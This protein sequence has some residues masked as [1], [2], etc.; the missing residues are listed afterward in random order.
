M[1]P[2]TGGEVVMRTI[3]RRLASVAVAAALGGMATGAAAG[4]FAIGTS[5]F[6]S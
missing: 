6:A 3:G 4:G 5:E 1:E 2:Y